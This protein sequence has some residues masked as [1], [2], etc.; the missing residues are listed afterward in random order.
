MNCKTFHP[1][2]KC[3]GTLAYVKRGEFKCEKCGRGIEIMDAEGLPPEQR[4][5]LDE[6]DAERKK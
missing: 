3:E 5:E 6:W 2:G 1:I 4:K